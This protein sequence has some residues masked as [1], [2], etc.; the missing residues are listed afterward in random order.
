MEDTIKD[1]ERQEGIINDVKFQLER[2]SKHVETL[3]ENVGL[4]VPSQEEGHTERLQQFLYEIQSASSKVS[5]VA[6]S[7]KVLP[8]EHRERSIDED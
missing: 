1:R 2:I 4:I 8:P 5:I 3:K 6:T 7:R